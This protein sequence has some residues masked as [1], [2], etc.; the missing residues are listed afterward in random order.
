MGIVMERNRRITMN[1]Y[2]IYRSLIQSLQ[3]KYGE[4]FN[5]VALFSYVLFY[6]FSSTTSVPCRFAVLYHLQTNCFHLHRNPPPDTNPLPTT[7]ILA[8]RLVFA[9]ISAIVLAF[10]SVSSN[11]RTIGE[12]KRERYPILQVL[13]ISMIQFINLVCIFSWVDWT[14]SERQDTH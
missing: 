13:Y 4:R 9:I 7:S 14:A 10:W 11:S 5:M 1:K 8:L 6:L 12:I 3:E 2:E